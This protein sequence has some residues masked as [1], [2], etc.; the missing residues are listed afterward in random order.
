[1]I[2]KLVRI[3][4]APTDL[5]VIER[6]LPDNSHFYGTMCRGGDG[7]AVAKWVILANQDDKDTWE[8]WKSIRETPAN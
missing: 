2:G 8:A 6:K 1:M 4:K 5:M 7:S 3:G